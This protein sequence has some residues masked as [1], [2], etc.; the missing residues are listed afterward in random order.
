MVDILLRWGADEKIVDRDGRK[1]ASVVGIGAEEQDILADVLSACASYLLA[2]APADCVW[3]RRRFLVL[4]RAHYPSGRVQLGCGSMHDTC[5]AKRTRSHPRPSRAAAE[6]AGVASML[7]G[8]GADPI[9]LMGD[10]AD[11]IFQTIVGHL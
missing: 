6:W 10:G 5:I 2:N 1:A 4:C 9:S 7:M 3:R 11:L 8:V